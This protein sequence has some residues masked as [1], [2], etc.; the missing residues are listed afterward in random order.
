MEQVEFDIAATA[1]QLLFAV[2]LC[3]RRPEITPDQ[4]GINFQEGAA[5]VL[6]E[7][8]IGFPVAGIVMV[9]E[10]AADAAGFLTMW[11][12]EIV[13]APFLLLV[14]R[15]NACMRVAGGF[16]G[17]VEGDCVGIFLGAPPI[18]NRC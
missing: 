2:G 12:I 17:G 10:D 18:Q 7:G 3:P 15:R 6:R 1:D 5:D 4:L 9:V 11:Q 14:V 13:V 8:E 16:H